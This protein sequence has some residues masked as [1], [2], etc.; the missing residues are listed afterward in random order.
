MDIKNEIQTEKIT[1]DL[2]IST[3]SRY[4]KDQNSLEIIKKAYALAES[5]HVGQLRKSGEPYILHPLEVTYILALWQTGPKTI[6][7]GLMHDVIEDTNISK[8]ELIEMFDEDIANLV[9]SVTKLTQLD[10]VS[11]ESAQAENH[12]KMLLAM[13]RDIRV[14]LIKLADRLHNI[15]TLKHLRPDKQI[16]ISRETMDIYVPIAH[17]LGMFQVKAE[18]ED[19]CLRYLEPE[20]FYGIVRLM[21]KKKSEREANVERMINRISEILEAEGFNFS[22][23]GRIKN[24]YSIYKKMLS[25]DKEFEEIYDLLAIRLIVDSLQ[26]C[27]AA[28]G[29][30]HANFKPIPNRFKD[31]IAMPKPN[32]YQ[33]LHTTVISQRGNIYE[34]QIR[35]KEMDEIAEKGVAAHWAYKENARTTAQEQREIQDKLKWYETLSTYENEVNDAENL[36]EFVKEDIFNANIYVFTPRGDVLDFPPKST[37]VDFAYRVHTDL[38]HR[39]TGAIVNGRIVPLSYHLKMGDVV[40]IKSN[41]N[42]FGPSEEWLNFVGTTQARHK[43]RQFFNKAKRQDNILRGEELFLAELKSLDK[44]LANIDLKALSTMHKKLVLSSWEDLYHDLGRGYVTAKTILERYFE[45]DMV[46]DE[47][48]LVSQINE[49]K[50][51]IQAKNRFGIVVDGLVN[52][53]IKIAKCCHPVPGDPI[54]GFITK[55]NGIAIHHTDCANLKDKS[56][57]VDVWFTDDIQTS[58]V[59]KIRVKAL[60]RQ[61]ILSDVITKISSLNVNIESLNT[62]TLRETAIIDLE[63]SVIHLDILNKSAT[64]LRSIKD[65][66][67]VERVLR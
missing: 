67:S 63:L 11:R 47:G 34:I 42:S 59:A 16:R 50:K 65:V 48:A 39:T 54:T 7:A 61:N 38:G 4:V 62:N 1:I 35:T 28:L 64:G 17:R 31:Y 3:V 45:K 18:F 13:S 46:V 8:A 10:Y 25:G 36:L 55:T 15:R 5:Q 26:D 37:P 20:S 40:E 49:R 52:V 2:I 14:I 29:A 32:M 53:D 43:I 66:F 51:D 56:R 33:S 44:T 24:I 12:R 60:A 23:K 9:D 57:F 27:Y 21:K 22:I 58:F 41:R 30:I 19:T 6:A